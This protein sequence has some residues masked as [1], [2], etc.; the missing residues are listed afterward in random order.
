MSACIFVG[1]TLRHQ[2]VAAVLEDAVCLPPAAQGDVYRAARCHRPRAIGIVDGYFCGAPSVWHK[3]ILWALS[4][5]VHVF[6]GASM[7]ALRAAELHTLGMRGVGWIFEAFRDSDLEDDDEVAV[8][9]GPAEM[10]FLAASEPM[11]NIRSTLERAQAAGVLSAASRFSLEAFGKS[12][13]YPH[14]CWPTILDSAPV[15]G[16][17]ESEIAALR[18]WLP[19]QRIDQK[20]E[21]GL[22]MLCAMRETLSR[23]ES[24][25]PAFRFER[26]YH[27]EDMVARQDAQIAADGGHHSLTE[28]LVLDELRLEGPNVYGP[29]RERATM[30]LLATRQN[31]RA[32]VSV[33]NEMFRTQL[34]KTR[35]ALGLFT[36]TEL[37]TRLVSDD[38]DERSLLNLVEDEAR[39]NAV[40]AHARPLLNQC[41]L[42]ELRLADSYS[43][44]AERTHLKRKTLV[45]RSIWLRQ[46]RSPHSTLGLQFEGCIK[47]G[48]TIRTRIQSRL[49][50]QKKAAA[51][52]VLVN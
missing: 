16:I 13:F 3:E 32:P 43:R 46:M 42:D 45:V 37:D 9:H 34:A 33:S 26:T 35:E 5:G 12:L 8:V 11:V 52:E 4:Q 10:G 14:R 20:R 15:C 27:F 22:A 41:L 1:P 51:L 18:D 30:R 19:H 48:F 25:Q 29:I 2:D 49:S 36:R 28:K 44:F 40:V 39:S 24:F 31:R 21:D 50:Q 23:P 17:S 47:D 6:G 7:G 38:L